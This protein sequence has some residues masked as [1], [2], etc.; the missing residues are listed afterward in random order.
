MS[1]RPGLGSKGGALQIEVPGD[2]EER[3]ALAADSPVSPNASGV[4]SP[5]ESPSAMTPSR[6]S[7]DGG[8]H[9]PI[10]PGEIKIPNSAKR[11]RDSATQKG[12]WTEEE[13]ELLRKLVE[14]Y[15]PSKWSLIA[16]HMENRNGKQ[17]R[18]RWLNHL[19]VGIKKGS[20]TEVEE[21][22]LVDAH[23]RLG[24][25]WSEIA[26]CI[27]GRSD[28]SIKN[29]WNSTVRRVLRPLGG[30]RQRGNGQPRRAS[31]VLEDYAKL[32]TIG[33]GSDLLP[34]R[35]SSDVGHSPSNAVTRDDRR[36]AKRKA[37][38]EGAETAVGFPDAVPRDTK[39]PLLLALDPNAE[40]DLLTHRGLASDDEP[41]AMCDEGDST[42][43]VEL[44]DRR[45]SISGVSYE[46]LHGLSVLD[47]PSQSTATKPPPKKQARNTE[48]SGLS[49]RTTPDEVLG[50]PPC[51][52]PGRDGLGTPDAEQDERKDCTPRTRAL[53]NILPKLRT[54]KSLRSVSN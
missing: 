11:Y 43:G 52:P 14:K 48:V 26:K 53:L 16:S 2:A 21:Q 8:V 27:P 38:T 46:A 10:L 5:V 40:E 4:D 33:P 31:E 6:V 54:P 49:L 41:Q 39:M 32:V 22:M 7:S 51:L 1:F 20:W 34:Q 19:S 9:S 17:C 25:A 42:D 18:E 30:T 23:Q 35:S 3:R 47:G 36:G 15:T 37:E 12:P 24:N 29:H 50:D 45:L 44:V 13:D 28:N